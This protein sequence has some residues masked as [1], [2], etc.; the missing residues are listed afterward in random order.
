MKTPPQSIIDAAVQVANESPCAK[1]QRGVVVWS[2]VGEPLVYSV[3]CNAQP[4][5]LACDGSDACRA[6]CG[7]LCEH[8]EAAALR[9]LAAPRGFFLDMLH[10][11]TVRG[12]LVPSGPPS[13]PDCSKAT[14]VDG[15]ISGMWL[16]Q[17]DGW[18]RYTALDFHTLSLASNNLPI[19]RV[20]S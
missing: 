1:S 18:H 9:T 15:R 8:A 7:R 12:E 2:S 3:G 17:L 19:I 14:L 13:C 5:P 20:P 4:K 10:V 6:A 11:K 16:Y